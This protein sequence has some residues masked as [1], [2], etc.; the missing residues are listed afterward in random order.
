MELLMP[1]A[2]EALVAAY[3]QGEEWLDSLWVYL[4]G[5]YA[6]LIDFCAKHLPQINVVP[7]EATYLAWLDCLAIV[8]TS[9]DFTGKLLVW[10]N[11]LPN[12]GSMFAYAVEGCHRIHIC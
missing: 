5:N 3:E 8:P 9:A 1:F 12:P 6:Y 4:H 10:E 2:I 7:L 11:V